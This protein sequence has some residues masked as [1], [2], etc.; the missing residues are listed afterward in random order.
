MVFYKLLTFIVECKDNGYND[1]I[2]I[3]IIGHD[4]DY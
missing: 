3:L 1:I 4:S 2:M